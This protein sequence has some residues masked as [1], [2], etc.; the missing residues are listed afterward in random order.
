MMSTVT[1]VKVVVGLCLWSFFVAG[2]ATTTG[3]KAKRKAKEQQLF[4]KTRTLSDRPAGR[5]VF[6]GRVTA[7]ARSGAMG[8]KESARNRGR[9]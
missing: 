3:P 9:R 7:A 6:A 4:V 2:V 1:G 8:A 5:I